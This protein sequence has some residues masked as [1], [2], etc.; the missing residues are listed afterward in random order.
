MDLSPEEIKTLETYK[1]I[2]A[3]RAA[4]RDINFWNRAFTQFQQYLPHG[5]VLDVGCGCGRDAP[6]FLQAQ[7]DYTGID[8]CDEMIQ[9]AKNR[10]PAASFIKMNMYNLDFPSQNFD[11]IWAPASLIH[12]PKKNLE[13]VLNEIKR[14]MKPGAVSF[15]AMKEGNGEK[16]VH[17]SVD[18]KRFYAFYHG[19]EFAS[20]LENQ[21]FHILEHSKDMRDSKNGN[22]WLLY[23]TQ[24]D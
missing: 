18:D 11:G 5:K 14:V 2:A 21:G 9:E 15:M 6:F 3:A 12:I 4:T 1:K 24:I 13:R 8:L 23:Y 20:L 10:A 16:I 19:D 17:K 7:Y 22:I